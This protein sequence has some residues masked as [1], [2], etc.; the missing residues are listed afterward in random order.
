MASNLAQEKMQIL[1]QKTYYQILVTT[2][3]AHDSTDFLPEV[4][5]YDTGYFPPESIVEAGVTYTR[6][7]YVQSLREDSGALSNLAPGTP[8]VGMKRI[9]ISV[10]W[11]QGDGK[12]KVT[13]RSV[14]SNPDTVMANVVFNGVVKSTAGAAIAGGFVKLVE[15]AGWAD[16]T[17]SNGNYNINA[18]PGTFT[19]MASATGYYNSTKSVVIA[20]GNTQTNNFSLTRIAAGMINGYPWLIDHLVI[21]Q[22]VGSSVDI[23]VTPAFDQ[24]Y[25]ELFNP[26]TVTWTV[27]GNVGL[28]FRRSVDASSKVIQLTYYNPQ[29][30]PGGY[31]LFANTGTVTTNGMSVNADAVWAPTNSTSDFPYFASQGNI[32][33]VDADG[34]AE[35]SGALELYNTGD[36]STLDRVGWD[37]SGYPAP[38][39]EGQAIVQTIGLS[40]NELYARKTS[41]GDISGV[42]WTLGP[43]Y[44]SNNN[45]NDFYDYSSAIPVPPHNSLSPVTTVVSGTPAAGAVVSCTDGLSASTEAVLLGGAGSSSFAYFSLVNVATGTWTVYIT[46]GTNALPLASGGVTIPSAGSVVNFPGNTTFLD[47][48]RN[49]GFVTGHVR[50]AYGAALSGITVTSGGANNTTT[51]SD[52]SYRLN[53]LPGTVDITANPA[54]GGIASYVTASSD[55]I[56]VQTGQV[57]SGVDFNLYRGGRL[58]GF[59]TRDGVNGLPGVALAILDANSIARDQQVS[60]TDG[61]FTSVILSTGI[62]TVYPSLGTLE[63]STPASSTVTVLGIGG[64]QFS[65]TFTVAG[66]L[67]YIN[68]TVKSGGQPIKTGVLIVVTTTTLTGSPAGPPD[69]STATLCGP[70]YYLVSSLEDGTYTAEVRG[71][72]NP[73]YRVYAYFPTPSGS[74]VALSTATATNVQVVAGQTTTGV[75]FSW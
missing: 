72:T 59:V 50:D 26:S 8:D 41:T 57:S 70:P 63:T 30:P 43:A 47:E 48:Y 39:Y 4:V 3:P 11:G 23:S 7:T 15:G 64:T 34:A 45:N 36:G 55:T 21:S 71:S 58:S 54:V 52:G 56:S 51:A 22:V 12:R 73:A 17:D 25:V 75:N 53:V 65:S 61:R 38:F 2:A 29:I 32:I 37:K 69:L 16:T 42:T 5:D 40:R 24:E 62:Y 68:G 13:V 35:G 74:T 20:A 27:A 33:P 28:K 6:Y 46:S 67:G 60:G 66:A 9:T 44:D 31:Y 14:V 19:L 18:T 49:N 10:V 1:K